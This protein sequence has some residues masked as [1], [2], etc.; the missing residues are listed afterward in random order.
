MTRVAACLLRKEIANALDRNGYRV[1]HRIRSRVLVCLAYIAVV[2]SVS[3]TG[4][5]HVY[6]ARDRW[7]RCWDEVLN[8]PSAYEDWTGRE[9][10][11]ES[12]DG[13]SDQ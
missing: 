8:P 4:C 10:E 9:N 2:Q 1:R 12:D 6:Q 3:L 13:R 7:D 11:K 5:G